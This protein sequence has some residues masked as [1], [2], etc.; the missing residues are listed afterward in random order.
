MYCAL[1]FVLSLHFFFCFS[2]NVCLFVSTICFWCI[3]QNAPRGLI[4]F[5]LSYLRQLRW[6]TFRNFTSREKICG[7]F[8]KFYRT[9]TNGNQQVLDILCYY[10]FTSRHLAR[11]PMK[12]QQ[13]RS[14]R[15]G[16]IKLFSG[17][18]GFCAWVIFFY[19]YKVLY[20]IMTSAACV[21]NEVICPLSVYNLFVLILSV[22]SDHMGG[23]EIS[24]QKC[25]SK[26]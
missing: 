6:A 26:L 4:K 11:M 1:R 2:L 16:E 10:K 15:Y 5:I 24:P 25:C 3:D 19:Y 7:E 17:I 22:T 18:T 21:R 13:I 23:L 14:M 20:C 12:K 9:N 8:Q